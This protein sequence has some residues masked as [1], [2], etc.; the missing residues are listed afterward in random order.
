MEP[1]KGY[2]T[3][4]GAY[5]YYNREGDLNYD[6]TMAFAARTFEENNIP[7]AWM[8]YDSWFY[9]KGKGPENGTDINVFYL[10]SEMDGRT[11]LFAHLWACYVDF[12]R[13]SIIIEK[14]MEYHT[15]THVMAM[16][17]SQMVPIKLFK[18]TAIFSK[19]TTDGGLPIMFMQ[20]KMAETMIS[21]L[22]LMVLKSA[23]Q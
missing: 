22:S 5:Y 17:I 6:E 19:L 2:N 10:S 1:P 4:A 11:Y 14:A 16:I 21:L 3:N 13:I 9:A 15:G 7:I 12:S 20:N 18:T 8:Q 23:D